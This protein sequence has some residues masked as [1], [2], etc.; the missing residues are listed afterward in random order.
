MLERRRGLKWEKGCS[1]QESPPVAGGRGMTTS[2]CTQ[3]QVRE[4]SSFLLLP[5]RASAD[6]MLGKTR[7]AAEENE[8]SR[9]GRVL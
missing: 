1:G 2:S 7:K 6:E 3:T 5:T 4:G 9:A 8:D